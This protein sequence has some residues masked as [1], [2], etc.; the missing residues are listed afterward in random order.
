MIHPQ[1]E[2]RFI[3]DE[4]GYGVFA[5]AFIPRGTITWVHDQLD[6][7]FSATD[8]EGFD[9]AHREI[10]DRFSYRNAQGHYVFCWDHARFMNHSAQPSCLLTPYG[11]EIA[12]RDI[13][14]D[15]E[16]TNDYGCF[17]II[18]PF[19]PR[20]EENGR[21]RIHHGDLA[22]YWPIWDRQI[23]AAIERLPGVA[24]PLRNL[25]APALWLELEAAAAGQAP[26][27]S[28]VGLLFRE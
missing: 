7:E 3:D 18:E 22:H 16:L 23:A 12:I 4:V 13:E 9:A 20:P 10:L 14:P 26:L 1:T 6:R 24:Q 28:T 19:V 25:I 17:N 2:V 21:E 27:R 11:M 5:K 15:D 8:L